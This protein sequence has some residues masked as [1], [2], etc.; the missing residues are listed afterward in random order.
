MN[1]I[2]YTGDNPPEDNSSVLI[3]YIE[4]RLNRKEKVK[5][6]DVGKFKNKKLLVIGNY[7]PYDIAEEILAYAYIEEYNVL[8]KQTTE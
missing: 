3:C 8:E 5:K 4:K 1:W 2:T 6:Y 7:F